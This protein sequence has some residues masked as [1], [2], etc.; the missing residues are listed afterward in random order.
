MTLPFDLGK[1]GGCNM[2]RFA[3]CAVILGLGLAVCVPGFTATP[4]DTDMVPRMS[5]E[6]LKA[7]IEDPSLLILDVRLAGHFA[8][9]SAK[10]KGALWVKAKDVSRWSQLFPKNS[11]FVLY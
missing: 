1:T 11:T 3:M 10:I 9:S 6:E 7:K 8:G 2:K 5:K 4:A